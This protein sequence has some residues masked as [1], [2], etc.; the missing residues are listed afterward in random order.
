MASP[1]AEPGGKGASRQLQPSTQ[2]G[3]KGQA[4]PRPHT[5][6][7]GHLY[8]TWGTWMDSMAGR[9]AEQIWKAGRRK[10][11]S[12]VLKAFTLEAPEK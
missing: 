2:E 10:G 1:Q 8:G 5:G 4:R 9:T 6:R 3:A 12:R 11:H 7:Q